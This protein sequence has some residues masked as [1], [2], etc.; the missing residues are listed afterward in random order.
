MLLEN[1]AE[2]GA[3]RRARRLLAWGRGGD[4][5]GL[6]SLSVGFIDATLRAQMRE[7]ET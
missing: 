5:D 6:R 4:A 2:K 7:L 1:H 3:S